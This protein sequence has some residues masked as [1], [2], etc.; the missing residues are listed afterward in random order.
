MLVL[1][2][3][4]VGVLVVVVWVCGKKG[5]RDEERNGEGE[6]K[7]KGGKG[8]WERGGEGME[9]ERGGEGENRRNLEMEGMEGK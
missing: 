4:G 9:G 2:Y 8:G 7:G 5:G 1:E 6:G 3:A